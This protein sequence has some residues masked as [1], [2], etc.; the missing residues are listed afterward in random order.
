MTSES[1][2]ILVVDISTSVGTNVVLVWLPLHP[3]MFNYGPAKILQCWDLKKSKFL[4][5]QWRIGRCL[6]PFPVAL[7]HTSANAVKATGGGGA[8][9]L[10]APRVQLSYSILLCR[11]PDEKA[12]STTFKVFGMT[13][14]GLEPT[15]YRL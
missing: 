5:R 12:V 2:V 14:P 6:S 3:T 11:A 1:V 10:V 8:G 15:T 7:G 4:P 13:L 9:P